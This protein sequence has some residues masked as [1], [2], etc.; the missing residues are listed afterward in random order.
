M[1]VKQK[2]PDA[3]RGQTPT[4][5]RALATLGRG[6]PA[7]APS[8]VHPRTQGVTGE[9]VQLACGGAR[10]GGLGER[11]AVS[12]WHPAQYGSEQLHGSHTPLHPFLSVPIVQG[13]FR[14][15]L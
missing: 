3:Q 9:G 11:Q 8:R 10:R 14:L 15:R 7:Q 2:T 5:E 6:Q 13:A 1:S 12:P 4:W